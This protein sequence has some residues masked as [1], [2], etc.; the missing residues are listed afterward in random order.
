MKKKQ[1]K[2]KI[3]RSALFEKSAF[4]DFLVKFRNITST[5]YIVKE[6]FHV[7]WA[8]RGTCPLSIWLKFCT[9]VYWPKTETFE[10]F[11]TPRPLPPRL[12]PFWTIWVWEHLIPG[13]KSYLF[14]CSFKW[15]IGA[16]GTFPHRSFL[17]AILW[18]FDSFLNFPTFL[19]VVTQ[20]WAQICSPQRISHRL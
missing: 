8:N 12:R 1:T 18:F 20:F 15:F 19:C 11:W 17:Q 5:M 6:S 13:S 10:N 16:L 7:K 4:F 3:F 2:A 14:W 9:L